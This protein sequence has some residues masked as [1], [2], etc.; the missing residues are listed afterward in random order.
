MIS[1]SPK[2]LPVIAKKIGV[3]EEGMN[4]QGRKPF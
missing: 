1:I 3:T 4:K 2:A